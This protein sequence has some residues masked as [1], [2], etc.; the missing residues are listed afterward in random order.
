MPADT[1]A[2]PSTAPRP[3]RDRLGAL[4]VYATPVMAAMIVLGFASGLPLYMVFQK[5]SFWLRLEGIERSTI[6]FF[7]WVTFAYSFKVIWSPLVDRMRIPALTEKL[8]RRRSWMVAAIGGTV[9]G[10]LLV[11]TSSPAQGLALVA[12]GALLL[13]FSGATLDIAIDAWRIESAPNEQQANMA[14]AYSLGY[15]FAYI[16]AGLGLAIA[17]FT[18]WNISFTVMAAAMAVCGALVL[19]MREPDV[20]E[21]ARA[22]TQATFV[23]RVTASV[24]EPFVQVAQRLGVWFAPVCLL[25]AIYRLSDFTM[26]VMASPLYADLGFAPAAVGA[27]QSGPGVVATLLGLFLGGLAAM[28]LGVMWALVCGGVIAFLTNGAYAWLA[29]TAQP[30]DIWRLTLALLGDNVA[31]GYATTV[32]IAYMSGLT[33]PRYAATQYALFGF[34]YSFVA[35]FVSGFSGVLADA[36]GYTSFFLITASYALPAALLTFVIIRFGTPAARALRKPDA[37]ADDAAPQTASA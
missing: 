11:A 20:P 7:Y 25:V 35:K 13:A 5:L 14:A 26:G 19:R 32:F 1:T 24:V 4:K 16:F 2:P 9:A 28:R 37:D 36:V 17:D 31:G 23:G 21:R 33:D 34:F 3:W 8:G 22:A 29:A 10:L 27:L 18:S 6:G 12:V 15:R 30:D